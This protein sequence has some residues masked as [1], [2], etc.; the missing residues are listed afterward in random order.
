[1]SDIAA[2]LPFAHELADAAA[3][4]V[5]RYYRSR[6]EVEQ[7]ADLSPVTLADR[8]AERVMRELIRARHPGHGIAG[9]EH[10]RE[11]PDA[12]LVWCLDPI[13]GT[14]SFVCGRPQFGIL[15]GLAHRGRPV[16]GLIDQPILKERWTG[17]EG[18]AS[19]WNGQ[20]I[21]T[22]PCARL[23]DAVLFTTSPLM[24]G[25]GADRAAYHRVERA[26]R[27][28]MFGGDCYSYGLLAM[29]F[30]DLVIEADLDYYDFTA[31]VPV[32]EGAGGVITDWQGR[33]L[34][35]SSD[36]R[37]VAAGDPRLH[38]AAL[39]LLAGG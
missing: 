20:E 12:P 15:V 27:Q 30:A 32:I 19:L 29:G 24:F 9:E 34:T 6:L 36:G 5:V 3:R 7:K 21:R 38:A 33:P 8:E 22:R 31:L 16:L 37:V 35:T 25:E 23:E 2:H 26:V 10:G 39:A 17:A 28:P 4:V 1:M 13:D 11:N 18:V 14:K